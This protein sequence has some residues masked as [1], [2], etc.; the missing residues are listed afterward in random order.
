LNPHLE[1]FLGVA[2]AG[3]IADEVLRSVVRSARPGVTVGDLD[4]LARSELSRRDARPAMLGY[5]DAVALVPFSHALSLCFNEQIAGASDPGRILLPGDLATAD[6][7]VEHHG[8][9]A[10]TAVSWVIPGLT[11]PPRVALA[12]ASR[13]VTAAGVRAIRPGSDWCSI[14]QSM[15]TEAARLGVTLLQ[16]FDGHALGRTMHAPP[17]LPTHPDE[18]DRFPCVL[19]EP[20]MILTIEPVIARRD[21]GCVRNAWLE[22]TSDGSDACFTEVTVAVGAPRRS[23]S[24]DFLVLAGF[25]DPTTCMT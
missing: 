8:W 21:P 3:R 25:L 7:V 16:G 12:E 24:A 18:V 11:H 6:L 5:T 14:V 17:R 20:G 2:R 15:A 10:D 4:R 9:H 19:L 1:S 22:R 23:R 13:A